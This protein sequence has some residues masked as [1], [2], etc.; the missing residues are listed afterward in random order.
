LKETLDAQGGSGFS[1]ADLAG[2]RAG[3]RFAE[4]V[5]K[6]RFK[7]PI[8]AKSFT[9]RDFVPKIDSLPEGL[10][11]AD[12]SRDYG[13]KGDQRFELLIEEIDRRINELPPYR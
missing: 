8:L 11:T 13:G 4:G 6:N 1:F 9:V 7:L 12:F 5:L 10:Q 3:I 2:D